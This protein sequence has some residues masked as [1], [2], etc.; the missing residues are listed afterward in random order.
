MYFETVKLKQLLF[1]NPF[2]VLTVIFQKSVII[3]FFIIW[4]KT[5]GRFLQSTTFIS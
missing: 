5:Y 3:L 2:L 4:F 1:G